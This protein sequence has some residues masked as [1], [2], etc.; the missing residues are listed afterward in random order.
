V[1]EFFCSGTGVPAC[2]RRDAAELLAF[3]PAGQRRT[4]SWETF[5]GPR[6]EGAETG[7]DAHTHSDKAGQPLARMALALGH[8][9][10]GLGQIVCQENTDDTDLSG[11]M[12]CTPKLRQ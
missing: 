11:P 6:V 9:S 3:S 1:R 5:P 7:G 12:E 2:L 8:I 4:D 10:A